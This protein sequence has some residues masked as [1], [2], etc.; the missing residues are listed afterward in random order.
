MKRSI[1]AMGNSSG[2]PNSSA[3]DHKVRPPRNFNKC[4]PTL[5]W[6]QRHELPLSYAK[7]PTPIDAVRGRVRPEFR[8]FRCEIWVA[9]AAREISR[10]LGARRQFRER[11]ASSPR[12]NRGILREG[13][14]MDQSSTLVSRIALRIPF[15]YYG[16]LHHFFTPLEGVNTLSK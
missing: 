11:F 15:T 4:E 10:D 16:Q 3:R 14:L 13:S 6:L 1:C 8:K 9:R 12:R 5:A 2:A 7:N